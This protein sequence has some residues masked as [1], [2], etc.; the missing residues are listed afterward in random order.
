MHVDIADPAIIFRH[1]VELLVD[2]FLDKLGQRH[3]ES[4]K[5]CDNHQGNLHCPTRKLSDPAHIKKSPVA[6]PLVAIRP[7]PRLS[8]GGFRP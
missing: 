8:T 1:L 7:L 4:N 3:P 2:V 6:T 5:Q